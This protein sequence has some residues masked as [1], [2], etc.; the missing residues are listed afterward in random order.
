MLMGGLCYVTA[1]Q[2]GITIVGGGL[3][4]LSLGILLLRDGV[5][6]EIWDAG[7]Y[8]R[9]RVCGEFI[10]GRGL[11]ILRGLAPAETWRLGRE[12]RSVRLFYGKW[13]SQQF[14]LPE[15]A[16][17]ID[18]ATLDDAMAQAWAELHQT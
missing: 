9:H 13:R 8:P 18:R 16:V 10:S 14:F 7:S 11:E 4:G 2:R 17:S 1:V 5:P 6:V 3:A 15:P 12:G